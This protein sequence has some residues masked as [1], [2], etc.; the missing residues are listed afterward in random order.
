ME[1]YGADYGF[2]DLLKI[3]AGQLVS[4]ESLNITSPS[5]II[6]DTH[7]LVLWIWYQLR[8]PTH[9]WPNKFEWKDSAVDCYLLCRPD[10][11]WEQDPLREN[12]KDRLE[13]FTMYENHLKAANKPYLIVSGQGKSRFENTERALK[14]FLGV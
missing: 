5:I 8:F 6:S 3:T 12:P 11:D 13:L 14:R 9:T 2:D 4:Y 1:N 10:I 7:L